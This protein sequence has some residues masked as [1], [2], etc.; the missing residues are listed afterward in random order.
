VEV[1]RES[2][3]KVPLVHVL[4]LYN[5]QMALKHTVNFIKNIWPRPYLYVHIFFKK[6]V[7]I[8]VMY[9]PI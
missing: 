9:A 4:C 7:L 1:V 6:Q 8:P 2:R 3:A 5:K